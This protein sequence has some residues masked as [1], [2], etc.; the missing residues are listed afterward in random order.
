MFYFQLVSYG[1]VFGN[2]LYLYTPHVTL[3][4]VSG[5]ARSS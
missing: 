3:P 2:A 1:I 4:L 5:D